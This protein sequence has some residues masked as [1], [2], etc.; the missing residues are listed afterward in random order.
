MVPLNSS[1]L[2]VTKRINTVSPSSIV[3]GLHHIN[4][5][6]EDVDGTSPQIPHLIFNSCKGSS[7]EVKN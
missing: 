2:K 7:T 3:C 6:L 1:E 4:K 5:R